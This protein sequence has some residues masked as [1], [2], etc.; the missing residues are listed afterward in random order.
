M[1]GRSACWVPRNAPVPKSKTRFSYDGSLSA[2]PG[3][4]GS[5]GRPTPGGKQ[6]NSVGNR[7]GWMQVHPAAVRWPGVTPSALAVVAEAPAAASPTIKAISAVRPS[8]VV[9]VLLIVLL[10]PF[11]PEM[12]DRPD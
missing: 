2:N 11:V 12:P 3:V 7:P 6:S 5:G 10:A 8:H 1:S 9:M 4:P